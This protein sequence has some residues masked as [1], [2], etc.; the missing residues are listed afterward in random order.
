M[1][2]HWKA[3]HLEIKDFEYQ[4]DPTTSCES[5]PSQTSKP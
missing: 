2:Q 5:I 1:I 4:Y 3:L